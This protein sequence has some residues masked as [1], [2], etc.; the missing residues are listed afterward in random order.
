MATIKIAKGKQTKKTPPAGAYV[1]KEALIKD[2]F[3][4]YQFEITEGVGIGD[5]HNVKGSG[6]IEDDMRHAFGKLNVHLAC[7]DDVFKH[8]KIE[9]DDIDKYHNH[10]LAGIYHA[11]GIKIKGSKDNESVV[12]LGNKYVSSAGGRIDLVTPKIPLDSLSS[13]K[14]YNELKAVVD[15][16]REEVALYKEGKYTPVEEEEE[17]KP[18]P[19]Q[20]RITDNIAEEALTEE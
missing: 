15:N 17:Q 13:Y 1:I 5:T 2:D 3:C 7:I 16:I 12:I 20:L 6:V 11:T 18:N 10:D 8:S 4:N 9:I 14:W 19:R